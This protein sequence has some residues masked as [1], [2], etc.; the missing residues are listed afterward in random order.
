LHGATP[1]RST[2]RGGP[3]HASPHLSLLEVAGQIEP[4]TARK[5]IRQ[6]VQ[7]IRSVS[8]TLT[9]RELE[10]VKRRWRNVAALAS[11]PLAAQPAK[12]REKCRGTLTQR[13]RV[14]CWACVLG[15]R[16]MRRVLALQCL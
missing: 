2:G 12:M 15:R 11:S 1:W 7:D 6:L 13:G 10:D 16:F 14:P 9:E 3:E 4:G 8:Q 5:A